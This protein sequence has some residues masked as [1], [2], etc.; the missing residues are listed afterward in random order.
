MQELIK[1]LGIENPHIEHFD[2]LK[3]N[4]FH[5]KQRFQRETEQIAAFNE[6]IPITIKA[7]WKW[8]QEPCTKHPSHMKDEVAEILHPG[9]TTFY[10]RHRL[11][12]P[13]CM[14]ELEEKIR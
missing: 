10:P 5:C 2:F 7:F 13:T 9:I 1:Q 4:G 3:R 11:D 12:C 6:A 14:K 8:L